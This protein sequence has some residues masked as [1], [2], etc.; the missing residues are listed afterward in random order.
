MASF[1]LTL[2]LSLVSVSLHAGWLDR[3]AEGWAWYEEKEKNEEEAKVVS[4][5]LSSSE[6]IA[7]GRKR[8]EELLAEA[9]INPS[10]ENIVNYMLE[11]RKWMDTSSDFASQWAK[12]LLN[13]PELDPTATTYATSQ[14]GRIVQK[15][16][17]EQAKESLIREIAK[18]YGL[19]F[20]YQGK[21]KPSI[22][23]AKVV[24]A[25]ANKYQWKVLGVAVDGVFINEIKNSR[26]DSQIA[27]KMGITIFP[28]LIAVNPR[29]Q[30]MIPLAFGL[31]SVDK[32]EQNTFMQFKDKENSK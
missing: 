26:A 13:H 12:I 32:I 15:S 4:K 1:Q 30:E 10:E 9:L 2:I 5:N 14:Y 11:Q 25:F 27:E 22:A 20:F 3:K 21:E 17:E 6:T 7:E 24:E 23:F 18:E 31:Q 28:A 29:T 16:M 19:F 8:L